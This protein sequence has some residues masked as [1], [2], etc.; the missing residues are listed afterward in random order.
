MVTQITEGTAFDRK[1]RPF[2]RRNYIPAL[3]A[4][5]V[6]VLATTVIWSI[7]LSRTEETP[8]AAPC[9][10]PPTPAD[11]AAAPV[12][13]EQVARS[14]MVDVMP[15]KLIDT[16]VRVLNASGQGGQAA[17]VA[18]ALKDLGFAPPT[19]A[20]D[21]IYGET[22]LTCQGQI[23]FGPSGQAAAAA[24]WAVAPCMEL[25]QDERP[26]DVVDLA[27][28]TQFEALAQSDDVAAVMASLQP[29]ATTAPD[30]ALIRA[31]HSAAC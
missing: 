24:V 13:G 23:R 16:K 7:A 22:R 12:V 2:K 26:D 25:V 28:G 27:I 1:G 29:E 19:P 4:L 31:I 5:A 14:T 15:A 6:L 30:P 20:N 11:P 17:G 18:G 3:V 10:P 8:Q 21:P 9:N